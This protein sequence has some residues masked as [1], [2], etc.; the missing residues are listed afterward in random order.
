MNQVQTKILKY[1]ALKDKPWVVAKLTSTNT[2]YV[3]KVFKKY[4]I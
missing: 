4:G 3:K 2:G 1:D